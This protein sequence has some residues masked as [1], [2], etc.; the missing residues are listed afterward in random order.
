MLHERW[1]WSRD[2]RIPSL[3]EASHRVLEEVATRLHQHHWSQREIHGVQ[4][5]LEE[6]LANAIRHGN[7]SDRA[8]RVRVI[9][10]LSDRRVYLEIADEGTGFAP[11]QV[12]DPT[13][14]ENLSKPGGRG[15]LLMRSYMT[16][17][18][19][20]EIGNVVIMEKERPAAN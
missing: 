17:V 20:N 14:P 11:H 2:Q 13:T 19:Y 10:K 6:A 7:R 15:I 8:R 9:C 16:R 5:A 18:E 1:L 12:P 3:R 4:L